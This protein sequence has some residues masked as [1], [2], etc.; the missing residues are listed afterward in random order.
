MIDVR[1]LRENPEPARASQRARGADPALVDQILEADVARREA[2][3]NFEALRATQK[4]VS[5]SVG[6]A[7][8][9]ERP[10]I[11]AQA[12][13]LAEEVKAAEAAANAADAEADR[14]ARLLPNLVLDGVPVGGEDD[15]VVLRHA[16][17]ERR[18]FAA[19]G[20][21]PQDHLALGEGLD[22]IDTKRGAKVSGAR[23][24]YLK[25]IGA[26]L[27]LALMTMA[28][29]QALA[30][31]FVPMMTPTLVTPQVMGGTGFLNEHSEEIY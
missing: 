24:Y 29:D 10:A 31:G 12:K 20:F 1:S 4:E 30:N 16:G 17:P 11:L 6:R 8:K 27:E 3:Q 19:E 23:F 2:L 18:D 22:A 13:E 15:Y 5:K 28:M 14:L 26:R 9:E 25:G 7:S 21:E